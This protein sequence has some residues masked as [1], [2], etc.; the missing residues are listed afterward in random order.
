MIRC[1]RAKDLPGLIEQY[2]EAV[3]T[4][5]VDRRFLEGDFAR[6]ALAT[7]VGDHMQVPPAYSAISVD[8][9]RA[10][11]LARKGAE[12]ELAA[13]P[14]TVISREQYPAYCRPLISYMLEGRAD[15][16]QMPYRDAA[17]YERMGCDVLLGGDAV[18]ID[19]E[20]RAVELG[21]G[22]QVGYDA[23]CIAT[24]SSPFVPPFS[25][26]DTVA[27][28]HAFM[29]LDDALGLDAAIDATSRV[30]IVG[31]GL[32][33]LKCAEGI[34]GRVASITVC[35]LAD[36][37]LSSILDAEC[38]ALM[39]ARLEE[40]GI[41]LILD[42]V[43]NHTGADSVYFDKFGNYGTGDQYRHWFRFGEQFTHGSMAYLRHAIQ[44]KDGERI[45][46]ACYGKQYFDSAV[47]VFKSEIIIFQL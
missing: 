3:R 2:A 33:G 5:P 6:D 38:A 35:D 47:K 21:D 26:L 39:Q 42:G 28:K 11:A 16:E 27:S 15:Q 41:R 37:V 4:A 10:Y 8:G 46:V 45:Q 22:S 24:G 43:F 13:R 1:W 25:G 36:R 7:L 20:A 23:L 40:Q 19:P 18:G 31:A 9:M 34:C 32:I 29:T 17:F 30:L 44:R 12:V 14:I